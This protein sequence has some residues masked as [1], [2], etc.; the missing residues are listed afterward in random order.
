MRLVSS[1]S[2]ALV[3]TCDRT[4]LVTPCWRACSTVMGWPVWASI[5]RISLCSARVYSA[6]VIS[7]SPTRPISPTPPLKL[8]VPKAPK[9]TKEAMRIAQTIYFVMPPLPRAMCCLFPDG[10]WRPCLRRGVRP[11]KGPVQRGKP[12]EQ[13]RDPGGIQVREGKAEMA[14]AGRVIL[15]HEHGAGQGEPARLVDQ[16]PPE[17]VRAFGKR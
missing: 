7:V 10:F 1:S 6:V 3:T 17:H 16:P 13:C 5:E 2:A 14:R 9:P 12:V 11:R 15:G 8:T 4:R